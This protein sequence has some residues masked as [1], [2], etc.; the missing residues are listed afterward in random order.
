MDEKK[1][2]CGGFRVGEGL[3]IDGDILTVSETVS[4]LNQTGVAKGAFL[5]MGTK[6]PEWQVM[7]NAEGVKF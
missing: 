4:V 6:A 3:S 1:I 7:P 5:V 2:P